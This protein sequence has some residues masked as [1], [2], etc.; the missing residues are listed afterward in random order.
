[1]ITPQ[2]KLLNAVK[3]FAA[4]TEKCGKTKLMKLLY[5]LD[6]EHFKQTGKP[7]TN[8]L[9]YAWEN[10]PVNRQVY[11]SITDDYISSEFSEHISIKTIKC[12]DG[13]KFLKIIP[14]SK[15]NES[16]FTERELSLLKELSK[17]F[18]TE[19]T[20]EMIEKTHLPNMPWEKTLNEKGQNGLIDYKLALD[21]S[22]DSISIEEYEEQKTINDEMEKLLS[23]L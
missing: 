6:F 19:N 4:N 3:F 20:Q 21:G 18:K 2:E 12:K 17:E 9:Y 16:V 14:E 1:M 15:I 5:F 23:I 11:D 8:N 10:G 7:V 13:R 22:K